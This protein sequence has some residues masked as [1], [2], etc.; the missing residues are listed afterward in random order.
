[1]VVSTLIRGNTRSL[2]Y[3]SCDSSSSPFLYLSITV[4]PV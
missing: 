4:G 2:D 3:S 1:M